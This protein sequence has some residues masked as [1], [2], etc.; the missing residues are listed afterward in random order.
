[1][2]FN[3]P[4]L[5][6]GV[7]ANLL[8]GLFVFIR[9][10]RSATSILFF[11]LTLDVSCWSVANYLTL[12]YKDLLVVLYWTRIVMALAVPQALLFFL[13]IHT[14]P[15]QKLRLQSWIAAMLIIVCVIVSALC[16]SPYLFPSIIFVS[17]TPSPT[18]GPAMPVFVLT[19]VGLLLSGV[20]TLLMRIRRAYGIERTQFQI[21][22]FGI[23][24]MFLLIFIFNF[25]LVVVFSISSFISISPLYTLPF[26]AAT[27]YAVIKHR[28][29]DIRFV[30]ARAV[31]YVVV[32][33]L[34]GVS[35]A[36]IFALTTTFFVS[37]V[38]DPRT[39]AVSTI[40]ALCML[41]TFPFIK[42]IVEH[43][44]DAIFYKDRYDS[45][46]VLYRLSN[47]MARTLR[48]EDVSRQFLSQLNK[49]LRIEKSCLVILHADHVFTIVTEGYEKPPE[50]PEA[51]AVHIAKK[52]VIL[53][54]E[55]MY[56]DEAGTVFNALDGSI[57]FPMATSQQCIGVL[58]VGGK[59]SGDVYTTE[60]MDIL[61]IIAPE[62]AVALE[63]SLSYEEIH[64]F[65]ATLEDEVKHATS[66]LQVA[67]QKLE[68]LDK[69]KD[70]FVS[71]ASHELRT[72][73]TAIRSYVWMAINGKGGAITDKQ[74]YYLDRAFISTDRLIKL[75]NDML[76][77]SRIESGR[78]AIHLVDVNILSL[79][80]TVVEEMYPK[81]SELHLRLD[82]S[83]EDG[84]P[85]VIA[86]PDK[87]QEVLINF[88]GNA[89]KFTPK[90]GRIRVNIAKD[91]TGSVRV[92]ITDT[93][94]GID[95][96]NLPK[97]FTKFGAL[98]S[99]ATPDAIAAQSTGLGLYISKSIIGIHGG[100]VA[101]VSA[102][103]GKGSTFSFTLPIYSDARLKELQ[104]SVSSEGLGII[105]SSLDV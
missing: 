82:I 47:N 60:D 68:Q 98:R 67:N 37:T 86:D 99:G 79:V 95:P 38:V 26:V 6:I 97:L 13:L 14:L 4:I 34:F 62:I 91:L 28:F 23:V 56:D 96:T 75:V 105:H 78:M 63:N 81:L 53:N 22:G 27:A 77:I 3:L 65:N 46:K 73:L 44:T 55:D 41:L 20:V 21:I 89:M 51:A 87:I 66:D 84:L 35:Y 54:K 104:K 25:I 40:A 72:P 71:L 102:G 92:S 50:L 12:Q 85:D 94:V 9:N 42:R 48:F 18:P 29:L 10:R 32:I 17:G 74:R 61:S 36:L 69:L 101:A 24:L 59:R 49:E 33:S 30:M 90:G 5:I 7:A 31:S 11:L 8:L 43:A 1:M 16:I 83:S 2:N 15:H 76:N 58:C 93:G 88:I 45:Q 103:I 80:H 64:R 70:E 39:V 19:A 52:G 100:R 57:L